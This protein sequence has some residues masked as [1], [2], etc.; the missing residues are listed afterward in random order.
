MI[1]V[2]GNAETVYYI[3]EDNNDLIGINS[4]ISSDM[5]ILVNNNKINQIIYLNKPDA[6]LYPEEQFPNDKKFLKDFKWIEDQRPMDKSGIYIWKEESET[7]TI[8]DSKSEP[9][10]KSDTESESED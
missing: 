7:E 2:F 3:R 4:S 8:P 6:V 9:D 1:K 5:V 10:L